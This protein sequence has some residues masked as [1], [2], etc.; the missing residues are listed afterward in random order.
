MTKHWRT[1]A[2][3]ILALVPVVAEAQTSPAPRPEAQPSA[4]FGIVRVVVTG[5]TDKPVPN[6]SVYFKQKI[7]RRLRKDKTI[8]MNLKTNQEGIARSPE[9]EQG[10]WLIQIIVPGWK[11]YGKWYEIKEGN[12]EIRI[13]LEKPP[14]WY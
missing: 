6:A 13:K 9:L 4:G 1:V 2:L 11:T 7:E 5:D 10:M 3:A 14:K 12:Q 8:A